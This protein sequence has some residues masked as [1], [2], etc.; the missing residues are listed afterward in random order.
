MPDIYEIAYNMELRNQ[1]WSYIFFK[2]GDDADTLLGNLD[3]QVQ[4]S[5]Q[6][7]I[8]LDALMGMHSEATILASV[9]VANVSRRGVGDTAI[10]YLDR[11]PVAPHGAGDLSPDVT[12]ASIIVSLKGNTYDR[13]L[14]LSGVP[15]DFIKRDSVG[16]RVETANFNAAFLTF[17][18]Q[19][20]RL[21]FG[22]R[23]R[24]PPDAGNPAAAV[25]WH[26]VSMMA[27]SAALQV[28]GD[29]N[30]NWTVF[31]TTDAHGLAAN[32][33]VTFQRRE[34]PRELRG[35]EGDLRVVAVPTATTFTVDAAYVSR[36]DAYAPPRLRA[37]KSTYDLDPIQASKI[38]LVG[39]A[40]RQR[41]S[42]RG[43]RGAAPARRNRH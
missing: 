42:S 3:G 13:R 41:G 10:E 16:R 40:T 6:D 14:A 32:D 11:T 23:Y 30:A 7:F 12:N 35:L 33:L 25:S 36:L 5:A 28:G 1:E 26:T 8:W 34:I 31:T 20:A 27:P 4:G 37:R 43:P 17:K 24:V 39:F 22:V 2:S 9:Q 15:D 38:K 29:P 21:A 18:Q 19:L